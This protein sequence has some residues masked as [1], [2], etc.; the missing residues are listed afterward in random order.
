MSSNGDEERRRGRLPALSADGSNWHVW[1]SRIKDLIEAGGNSEDTFIIWAA[2][3]HD[4]LP[5]AERVDDD[6]N[7]VQ[8]P[9]D[10]DFKTMPGNLNAAKQKEF[11]VLRKDHAKFYATIRSS[12][13]DGD[14]IATADSKFNVPQLLRYLRAQYENDGSVFDRNGLRIEF[15]AISVEQYDTVLQYKQ[16]FDRLLGQMRTYEIDLVNDEEAVKLRFDEGLGEGWKEDVRTTD[17]QGM[18]Y[19]TDWAYYRIESGQDKTRP[20]LAAW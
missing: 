1:I 19:A 12:L 13:S 15:Q 5:A 14:I 11:K 9:V 4:L 17:A 18:D 8:D 20:F 7:E 16:A 3:E 2:Y 10:T 6:G